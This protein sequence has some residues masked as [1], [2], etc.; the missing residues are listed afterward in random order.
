M[1]RREKHKGVRKGWH[2]PPPTA[3]PHCHFEQRVLHLQ[4][5]AVLPLRTILTVQQLLPGHH[6]LYP[7]GNTS[8]IPHSKYALPGWPG[9]TLPPPAP[10]QTLRPTCHFPF[11]PRLKLA[12]R[13]TS[14]TFPPNHKRIPNRGI[15]LHIPKHPLVPL[16]FHSSNAKRVPRCPDPQP[17]P[18]SCLSLMFTG[19]AVQREVARS[20]QPAG[21]PAELPRS[22]GVPASRDGGTV[23]SSPSV[24]GA[25]PSPGHPA[26]S[27]CCRRTRRAAHRSRGAERLRGASCPR[28]RARRPPH[29]DGKELPK[30]NFRH[31]LHGGNFSSFPSF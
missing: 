5:E 29:T 28:W 24:T 7:P 15:P 8:W 16:L 14:G 23:G 17:H 27:L 12:P 26:G 30:S 1:L 31:R 13:L 21:L 20:A 10:Q 6:H 2:L 19:P 4:H 22:G 18:E 3:S 9:G 11:C 25:R